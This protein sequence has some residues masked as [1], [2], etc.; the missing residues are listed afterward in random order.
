MRHSEYLSTAKR[1]IREWMARNPTLGVP[2][3]ATLVALLGACTDWSASQRK[4][5]ADELQ[6]VSPERIKVKRKS[7][8]LETLFSDTSDAS[9]SDTNYFSKLM[10]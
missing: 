7:S 6:G 10:K 2:N 8:T 9:T 3:H 1:H 5:I 4:R